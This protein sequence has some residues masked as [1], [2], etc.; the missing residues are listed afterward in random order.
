MINAA[1]YNEYSG[2]LHYPAFN[3][4]ERKIRESKRRTEKQYFRLRQKV[5]NF[6]H[7]RK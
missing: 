4:I 1:V 6:P 2:V 7:E 5:Q 3:K